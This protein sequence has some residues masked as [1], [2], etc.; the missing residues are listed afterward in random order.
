[1]LTKNTHH[2][3]FSKNAVHT[4]SVNFCGELAEEIIN[5]LGVFREP[6]KNFGGVGDA[7]RDIVYYCR[8]QPEIKPR[9]AYSLGKITGILYSLYQLGI[10][11]PEKGIYRYAGQ[12]TPEFIKVVIDRHLDRFYTN[13]ELAEYMKCSVSTMVRSFKRRFGMTPLNYQTNAKTEQIKRK[14]REGSCSVKEISAQL[15]FCSPTYLTTFFEKQTG[16]TPRQ[17][18]EKI[19]T[20]SQ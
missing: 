10:T 6:V 3:Y 15:G 5:T 12:T 7:L 14:L 8:K 1:M 11:V 20:L 17:Y 4:I 9:I 13:E 2:H 18:K 16:L 19:N